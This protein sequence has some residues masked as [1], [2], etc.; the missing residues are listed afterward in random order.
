MSESAKTPND[1]ALRTWASEWADKFAQDYDEEKLKGLVGENVQGIK[2]AESE[3]EGPKGFA[4]KIV[5]YSIDTLYFTP[6]GQDE[7]LTVN[8]FSLI[9]S[10]GMQVAI[11]SGMEVTVTAAEEEESSEPGD[12]AAV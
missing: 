1:D 4:A 2:Q 6:E 8:R 3:E 9:T 12:E 11:L 10:E 7:P 5:G